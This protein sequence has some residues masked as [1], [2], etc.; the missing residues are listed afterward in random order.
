MGHTAKVIGV[1]SIHIAEDGV[2]ALKIGASLIALGRE[3]IIEPDWVEKIEQGREV[4]IATTLTMNDS[5]RLVIPEPL[6]SMMS[7]PGWFPFVNQQLRN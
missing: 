5:E 2:N 7:R 6:W 3:L 1:G 4:E